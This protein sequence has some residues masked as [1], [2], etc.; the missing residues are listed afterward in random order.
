MVM[1]KEVM[2]YSVKRRE[3]VYEVLLVLFN[4]QL[5]YST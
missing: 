3:L 1:F 2:A 4:K 5:K